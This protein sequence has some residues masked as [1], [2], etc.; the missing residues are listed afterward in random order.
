MGLYDA[1]TAIMNHQIAMTD[2]MDFQTIV[3]VNLNS[4]QLFLN[5][6]IV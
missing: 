4:S 3:E 5:V 2:D 1:M 6:C